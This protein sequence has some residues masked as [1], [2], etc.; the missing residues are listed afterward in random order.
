[1]VL[2]TGLAEA[3][4]IY[5]NLP[6]RD[7]AIAKLQLTDIM[8][9]SDL[10][11]VRP[12]LVARDAEVSTLG[13]L[14]T[15]RPNMLTFL[16]SR[17]FLGRLRLAPRPLSVITTPALAGEMEDVEGVGLADDP[18]R[19]FFEI[20]NHL[21]T[22]TGFYGVAEPSAIDPT[23]RIDASADV[24]A[25]GVSIGPRASVGA[26]VV[27]RGRCRIGEGAVLQAGV[28]VGGEG[29]QASAFGG[30]LL[31]MV[32]AGGVEIGNR[33]VVY[34]NAVIARAV[35]DEDTIIGEDCR[36]GN[37]AFV[38]HHVRLGRRCFVGHGAVV[39]GNV[40]VGDDA[41]IG[42]GATIADS[43]T[44]GAG[45]RISLGSAVIADVAG[46]EQMTGNV[47]IPHRQYLRQVA[48]AGRD[49]RAADHVTPAVS[50]T[51]SAK[52]EP[53][54]LKSGN[55][56]AMRCARARSGSAW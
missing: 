36:I 14:S 3:G 33:T 48:R 50:R 19:A 29:F 2:R 16:E 9:L 26:R 4:R 1:L 47:A 15:S 39:N 13:F 7:P 40:V 35:F 18:R 25:E 49:S 22:K 54:A 34:A 31:D 51:P 20:H 44:I 55:A 38:S 21:A 12:L 24:P 23:A 56:A 42:P 53:A 30:R 43:V 52:N 8:R 32:H 46:G 45:A 5:Q 6:L 28:V 11:H 41:W 27:V 17:R 37:L 10:A